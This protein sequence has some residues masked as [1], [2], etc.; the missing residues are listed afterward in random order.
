METTARDF[1]RLG[2]L[3]LNHGSWNGRQIVS[4][5]WLAESIRPSQPLN[6]RYGLL[7]YVE[8]E[9]NGYAAHGHLDTH[10]H[11][12]PDL[13]LVIVR[14]QPKPI[15]GVVEGEYEEKGLLLFRSIVTRRS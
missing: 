14:M 7:W 2:I 11:V 4:R 5:D 9:I 6:P 12:I 3:M 15:P 1:A 13:D 10:L 8:P